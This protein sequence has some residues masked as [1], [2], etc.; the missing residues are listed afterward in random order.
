MATFII[1]RYPVTKLATVFHPHNFFNGL[2]GLFGP[3]I[4]TIVKLK[5]GPAITYRASY[6]S[7]SCPLT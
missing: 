5:K 2:N 1:V 7:G 6:S 4:F 3:L